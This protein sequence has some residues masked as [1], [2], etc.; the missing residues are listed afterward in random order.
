MSDDDKYSSYSSLM[1]IPPPVPVT[2]PRLQN[3]LHNSGINL[4]G[5]SLNNKKNKKLLIQYTNMYILKLYRKYNKYCFR[6]VKVIGSTFYE[7]KID[8]FPILS[9]RRR[10]KKGNTIKVKFGSFGMGC[11]VRLLKF[12]KKKTQLHYFPYIPLQRM[13]MMMK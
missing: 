12:M 7:R 9:L 10:E 1:L 6:Q 5:C 8:C 11:N 4:R 2:H 3:C 13:M